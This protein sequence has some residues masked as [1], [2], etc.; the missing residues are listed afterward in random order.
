[1]SQLNIVATL[2]IKSEFR[3]AF[4]TIFKKLVEESQKEIGCI[5]YELN[6][7]IDDPDVYI[8]IETWVS[9]QAINNHNQTPHFKAFAS[10]AK[11][12]TEKLDIC[13]A[14]QVL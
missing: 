3:G 14:K 4:Q 13:I 12:H 8:V 7:R 10:F 5:R 1:M 2:K 9:K 6:Q 11:D